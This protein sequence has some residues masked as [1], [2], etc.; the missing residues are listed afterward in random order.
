MIAHLYNTIL[1]NNN[2]LNVPFNNS[3]F[4]NQSI[5]LLHK[6]NV[7]VFFFFDNFNQYKN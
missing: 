2:N 3:N 1:K 4:D 6:Y 7:N 5:L